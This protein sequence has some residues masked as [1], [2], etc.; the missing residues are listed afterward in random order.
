M[1]KKTYTT[2]LSSDMRTHFD[3]NV[4]NHIGNTL[5]DLSNLLEN[6]IAGT[7]T[8]ISGCKK[9]HFKYTNLRRIL[10][11]LDNIHENTETTQEEYIYDNKKWIGPIEQFYMDIYDVP[12]ATCEFI[13]TIPIDAYDTLYYLC[14]HPNEFYISGREGKALYY[15][16]IE[17][18]DLK[19]VGFFLDNVS[20]ERARMILVEAIK[21]L[22]SQKV[23]LL[24][25]YGI[26]NYNT[27]QEEIEKR[28]QEE[29][30][31]YIKSMINEKIETNE[32]IKDIKTH[33]NLTPEKFQ[34]LADNMIAQF[35]L[36]DSLFYMPIE[37][38]GLSARAL[39]C[40]TR[41]HINTFGELSKMSRKDLLNI[42]NIGKKSLEEI[43][44]VIRSHY[45][46]WDEKAN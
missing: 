36:E 8:L 16:Y 3:N 26:S 35:Y 45:P 29:I 18:R 24:L 44:G 31:T 30:N 43:I 7:D 34:I 15:R 22:K 40:L 5:Q 21:K 33:L 38:L 20:S 27:I 37:N 25:R 19:E 14:T 1:I 42:R 28:T 6:T 10:Y 23:N 9:K 12:T 46:Q 41:S 2:R 13:H 4:L 39:N 11:L 32:K 17:A